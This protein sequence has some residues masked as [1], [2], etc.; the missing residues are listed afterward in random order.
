[1][2]MAASYRTCHQRLLEYRDHM[3]M[4]LCSDFSVCIFL[5]IFSYLIMCYFCLSVLCQGFVTWLGSSWPFFQF[6]VLGFFFFFL[7]FSV[8]ISLSLIFHISIYLPTCLSLCISNMSTPSYLKPVVARRVT[9]SQRA[10]GCG[11]VACCHTIY[12]ATPFAGSGAA[13]Q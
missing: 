12:L 7:H 2:D 4:V 1:M 5:F 11:E 8:C 9:G 13:P 10:S 6:G 3:G